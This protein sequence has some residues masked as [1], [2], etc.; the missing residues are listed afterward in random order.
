MKKSLNKLL[1][2]ALGFINTFN[3][4]YAGSATVATQSTAK[5]SNV[6]YLS[7]T[8]INFGTLNLAASN[9]IN[10]S[11]GTLSVLCTKGTSYSIIMSWGTTASGTSYTNSRPNTGW[12][13][14]AN[15]GNHIAYSIQQQPI[16]NSL[17]SWGSTTVSGT[18]T[19]ANKDYTMYGEV[20]LNAYGAPAYPVPDN[21]SDNTTATISF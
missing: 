11:N 2:I 10:Y 4:A 15:T 6:C 12:M 21:Y 14:G 8:N 17:P 13:T 1:V 7:A 19:G 18:G 16:N 5:I 9:N 3:I 20:Q